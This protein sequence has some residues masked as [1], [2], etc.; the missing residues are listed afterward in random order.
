[1]PKGNIEGDRVKHTA[2]EGNYVLCKGRRW[3][4]WSVRG[5]TRDSAWRKEKYEREIWER[6]EAL[7]Q[8]P[9][10]GQFTKDL[11]A[12]RLDGLIMPPATGFVALTAAS[13]FFRGS[14]IVIYHKGLAEV[15]WMETNV[16]NSVG[17]PLHCAKEIRVGTYIEVFDDELSIQTWGLDA[18]RFYG[19]IQEFIGY[20][21]DYVVAGHS[22]D[23]L[24]PLWS[25]LGFILGWAATV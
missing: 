3:R 4:E 10:P 6:A 9:F 17:C 11:L 21:E 5:V 24:S 19:R 22:Y 14:N 15:P 7:T 8:C 13:P 16:I 25:S 23:I 12:Y 18:P 1:M 2:I 20:D